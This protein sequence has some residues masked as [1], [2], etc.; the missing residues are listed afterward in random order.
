MKHTLLV[1]GLAVL[2]PSVAR[3][4]TYVEL[5]GGLTLPVSDDDYSDFVDP[6]VALAARIGGGGPTIGGMASVEWS[7][8]AADSDDVSLNRLRLL[9]H[10]VLHHRLSPKAEIV[11]RIGAGIDYIHSH[12]EID[13]GIL[14]R[15]E[16]SDSDVGLALEFGGGAWFGIGSGSTQIGVELALPI[17]IHNKDGKPL[18]VD[19]QKIDYTAIDVQILG[20]VRLRL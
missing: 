13:G 6:S 14:G 19:D 2:A 17:G 18:D 12:V 3:A 10:L 5:G 9:G 7:P 16:G 4:E 20:G 11:G 1:V 8:L 15:I